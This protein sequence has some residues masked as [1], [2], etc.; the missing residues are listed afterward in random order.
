[1]SVPASAMPAAKAG[2]KSRTDPRTEPRLGL[3]EWL[4][5]AR[6]WSPLPRMS[7][8][9][10]IVVGL[11]SLVGS[12]A[13]IAIFAGVIPDQAAQQRTA[14]LILSESVTTLGSALLRDGNTSGLR[15]SLEFLVE[16]NPDIHSIRLRRESGGEYQFFGKDDKGKSGNSTSEVITDDVQVPIFQ[17]NR[18]W[19]ELEIQFVSAENQHWIKRYLSS[20]FAIIP[21][22]SLLSFPIFYLFLGKVLKELNPSTAV[23]SRVRTALDT[24]AEALLVLDLRGN[25]VL[26]NAA[27]INLT[28]KSMEQLL[29]QSARSLPWESDDH[30]VWEGSMNSS[31]PTR[32]DK[33][34]FTNADGK[35]CSFIV[36]CSP[37]I[38]A[39]DEIGGVLISMDDI[40][41]LEEQEILLRES[42]Q[43]AEEANS[44]KSTFL[45]NMSHEIRTPMNAI[46]GFTEVMRRG[47]KQSDSERLNYLNIISNSGQHLLELINDVLDLSKVESGAM[48]VEFLHSNCAAIANDVV[49]A[50]QSKATEK[51]I[52]LRLEFTSSLPSQ[53]M[54]DPSRLRQIIT[55]LV[56]N[57]IKFTDTGE[58]VI[59][60]HA[61]E[62]SGADGRLIYIEVVDSGIGMS[63]EQQAKIFDAFSQADNSIARRF[64]GTGLGLSISKQLTEAMNGELTVESEQGVGSTFRTAL[65]FNTD[66]YEWLEPAAIRQLLSQTK[67]EEH[68]DWQIKSS[69]VLVVDDGVENRQLMSILLG[70]MGLDVELAKNGKEGVDAFFGADKLSAFDLILMDIQMPIMDGYEAAEILRKRGATLP[71]VALTANAM[72]GFETKVLAAGFSHYMVKPIDVDKLGSLLT[73]LLGPSETKTKRKT[74][75]TSARKLATPAVRT[76]TLPGGQYGGQYIVS[77]L[78]LTDDRFIPIVDD[79]KGRLAGRVAELKQAL[80]EGDWKAQGD[81]G[82]WL[83]GSAASVGIEP[84]VQP[85]KELEAAAAEKDSDA[86][87]RAIGLIHELQS[88]I[89]ADPATQ[90]QTM[91]QETAADDIDQGPESVGDTVIKSSLPIE[92]PEF[93]EV[94]GLF[95]DRLDEQMQALHLAVDNHDVKQILEILH[96]LRG[97]GANVGFAGYMSLCDHMKHSLEDA[98]SAALVSALNSLEDFNR[99]VIAG[100]AIA[101]SPDKSID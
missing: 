54:T 94:V 28:G 91:W 87:G 42:M 29:G 19:G 17:R 97:S 34:G 80:S 81:I 8:R 69:R 31:E 9:F 100:W 79:F 63:I 40:T 98:S 72:K 35:Q 76:N 15:F 23:P 90:P 11:T 55:N 61:L 33:V 60:L 62:S 101:P 52:E 56:G 44:A 53:I 95:I 65:P 13:L 37:V 59:R 92:K 84:L 88:R 45:S 64:G 46:L 18:P 75:D 20:R 58:V 86:C 43:L 39:E 74:N 78:A 2:P 36:N 24:L 47:Q 5:T 96:W 89:L 57:A 50:L 25:I 68:V 41:R 51:N 66:E 99:R 14:H 82:H 67:H 73:T 30:F 26:A 1:M 38:T 6:A 77:K 83:K 49:Q 22:M 70:D 12:C 21:F 27:F 10:H 32:H 93:H 16:R 48:E 3:T 4:R 85:A 7:A 71:I